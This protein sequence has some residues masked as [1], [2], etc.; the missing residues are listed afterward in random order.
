MAK[1][2]GL[3]GE[4]AG[5]VSVVCGD[6]KEANAVG[7]RLKG[8][9]RPMYSNPPIHGARIVDTILNDAEL[10][11]SWHGSLKTMSSRMMDM[12]LNWVSNMKQLNNPHDWSHV[13]SQI[14]MFAF[15]GI[16]GDQV[17]ELADKHGIYLTGDG[18]ISIPGLNSGN[19]DYVTECFHAV[20]K[21]RPL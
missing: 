15:T 17:Q 14:G 16:N 19:I 1:N 20:T 5:C 21:D 18:R 2:F 11:K 12:R 13:T 8:I 7:T 9:A 3:Y 10:T 6:E 4:R